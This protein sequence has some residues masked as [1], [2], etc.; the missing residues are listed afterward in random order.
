M[1][2]YETLGIDHNLQYNEIPEDL[3][4]YNL[5]SEDLQSEARLIFD[6]V[7]SF[8][9][10]AS[11]NRSDHCLQVIEVN[12]SFPQNIDRISY[13]VQKAIRHR[14]LFI[15]AYEQRYL[16]LWR[17]FNINESTE[18]VYTQHTTCC[19]N[20]IYSEYLVE[21]FLASYNLVTIDRMDDELY[22]NRN[23]CLHK[24]KEDDGEE[25]YFSDLLSNVIK[26]NQCFLET[27]YASARFLL[28]WLQTHSVGYRT[29]INDIVDDAK[30]HGT[31]TFI[32]ESL[33]FDKNGLINSIWKSDELRF[34]PSIRHT[35][36]NP[37]VYLE[38]LP[39]VSTFA[40]ESDLIFQIEYLD[41]SFF[42]EERNKAEE[43]RFAEERRKAE[44]TRLAEERRKAEEA[45]LAE[46]RRRAEEARFAEEKRKEQIYEA[47]LCVF[48][49]CKDI[50]ELSKAKVSVQSIGNWKSAT[51]LVLMIET[52]IS[53]IMIENQCAEFRR[54]KVCQHCGGKFKGLFTKR[55][56][57]C[58]KHKDY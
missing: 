16:I 37:M 54:Q 1:T 43:A 8:V 28:D 18:N 58:G 17:N 27:D 40:D 25:L 36:K 39:E 24:T 9:L 32:E 44:K 21:D 10:R 19:T 7:D 14:V 29:S 35:G 26:L 3:I 22:C 57:K 51:Q 6:S 52:K 49:N 15:F 12:L 30:K 34:A 45:R 13:I 47:A 50:I 4:I 2:I 46:E 55:C 11:I 42:T 31:F 41:E 5:P 33:F 38:S 48:N 56:D 20:W 23:T 53:D